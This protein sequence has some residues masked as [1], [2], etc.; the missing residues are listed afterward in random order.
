MIVTNIEHL[1]N[2][3]EIRMKHRFAAIVV[4]TLAL[5]TMGISAE[6]L[7]LSEMFTSTG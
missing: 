7:T 1:T 6:R 5:F 4:F 3:G 2:L